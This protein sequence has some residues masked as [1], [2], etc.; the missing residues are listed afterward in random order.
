MGKEQ[1]F[2]ITH[3]FRLYHSMLEESTHQKEKTW[4]MHK[5]MPSSF[6][7]YFFMKT[8]YY[9]LKRKCIISPSCTMYSF[10]SRRTFP[11]SL[12]AVIEP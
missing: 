6:F 7:S 4:Q 12:A 5:A 2:V 9:T 10:P 8:K 1:L 3:E 11:A